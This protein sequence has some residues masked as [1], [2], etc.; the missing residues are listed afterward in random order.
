M[1]FIA[2]KSVF[3]S[4]G[5]CT[6]VLDLSLRQIADDLPE[7]SVDLSE[8]E[9]LFLSEIFA[10]WYFGLF[11]RFVCWILLLGGECEEGSMLFWWQAL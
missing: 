10:T 3:V 1:F 8:I 4:D 7:Q 11:Y 5:S 9:I 6:V 2:Y